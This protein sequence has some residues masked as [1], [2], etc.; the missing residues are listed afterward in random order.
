M[1]CRSLPLVLSRRRSADQ[2]RCGKTKCRAITRHQA[3]SLLSSHTIPIRYDMA[4]APGSSSSPWPRADIGSSLFLFCHPAPAARQ[5][6]RSVGGANAAEPASR[7]S[8]SNLGPSQGRP[9][10]LGKDPHSFPQLAHVYYVTMPAS[11]RRSAR[12]TASPLASL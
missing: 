5:S 3:P 10:R 9:R 1:S 2:K 8:L 11:P 12:T 6:W 4:S 7:R